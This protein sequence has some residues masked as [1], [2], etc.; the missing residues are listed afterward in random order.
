[1]SFGTVITGAIVSVTTTTN[2]ML[3][4]PNEFDALQVTDVVPML[5]NEP[6]DLVQLA[7]PSSNV[8]MPPTELSASPTTTSGRENCG[9]C[10]LIERSA[11]VNVVGPMIRV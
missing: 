6:D 3:V 11:T 7:P 4:V 8:T 1:M 5:K 10:P 2:E 9:G